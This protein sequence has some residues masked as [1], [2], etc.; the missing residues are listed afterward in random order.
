MIRVMTGSSKAPPV[1]VGE[2]FLTAALTPAQMPAE[3]CITLIEEMTNA[4]DTQAEFT[5][6]AVNYKAALGWCQT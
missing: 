4:K 1:H 5:E 2:D 3:D 6:S